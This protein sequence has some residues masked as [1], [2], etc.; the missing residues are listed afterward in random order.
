[1]KMKKIIIENFGGTE[2]LELKDIENSIPKKNEVSIAHKAIG[3]NYI[4]IYQRSGIYP[5]SLPSGLGLEASG[6]V[7]SIGEDVKNIKI[8]DRVCYC[9]GP[10]GAYA[11]HNNVPEQLVL[12]LPEEI[13][14]STAAASL[15]KGLTTYFLLNEVFKV[16]K[17]HTILFHA[18]AGGVGS[19]AVPWAKA[20][21]AK[22]IGTVGSDEKK[23]YAE[24]RGCDHVIN[25]NKESFKEKVLEL[26]NNDGV[27]VAYDSI[28]KIT[29]NDSLDCL[30]KRGLLVS[31]GNASG[32][33]DPINILNLM[34][35]GSLYVTRPTL[36][37][38]VKTRKELENASS[39]FFKMLI[40]KKITI[41]INQEFKLSEVRKAHDSIANRNTK[42]MTILI[43]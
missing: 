31:F 28:G 22:I 15:L 16:K 20:I 42:G 9:N 40:D 5:I 10:V 2:K 38:Y 3:V 30:S 11:T 8:G 35:K 37:D 29:V 43:P 41:D 17:E 27:P 12:K 25:Y 23:I 18:V 7:E 14:F 24:Q 33:V 19:I 26:T 21:G 13:S 39:E 36:F 4:D 32:V 6:I 1:M 34:K